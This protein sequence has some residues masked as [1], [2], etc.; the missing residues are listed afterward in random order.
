MRN[1]KIEII[2]ADQMKYSIKLTICKKKKWVH[3]SLFS[4]SVAVTFGFH[5]LYSSA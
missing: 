4:I 3:D 2:T 1:N 5:H